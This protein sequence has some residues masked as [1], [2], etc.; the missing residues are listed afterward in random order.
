MH[1]CPVDCHWCRERQCAAEGCMRPDAR[2]EAILSACGECGGLFVLTTRIRICNECLRV[3]E[4][5]A[6]QAED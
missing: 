1:I 2:V 3:D 5:T 4:S 6:V